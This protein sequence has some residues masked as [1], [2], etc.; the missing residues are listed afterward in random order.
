MY[1]ARQRVDAPTL[2]RT[3]IGAT[4]NLLRK[5]YKGDKAVESLALEIVNRWKQVWN[6]QRPQKDP[7][8]A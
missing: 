4:V 5:R 8:K 7:S 3:K 6:L 2:E 1:L